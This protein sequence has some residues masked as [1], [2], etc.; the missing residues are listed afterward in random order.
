MAAEFDEG[1]G[2]ILAA[3]KFRVENLLQQVKGT[4]VEASSETLHSIVLLVQEA[5]EEIKKLEMD[6][7]QEVSPR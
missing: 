3:I 5:M 1:I 4:R 6:L 2:Q 7:R